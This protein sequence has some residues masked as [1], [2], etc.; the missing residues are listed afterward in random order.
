[1]KAFLKG[2]KKFSKQF[3]GVVGDYLIEVLDDDPRINKIISSSRKK[4]N[5]YHHESSQ[6]RLS[7]LTKRMN[8]VNFSGKALVILKTESNALDEFTCIITAFINNSELEENVLLSD[9]I[10]LA[11]ERWNSILYGGK[12]YNLAGLSKLPPKGIQE[13]LLLSKD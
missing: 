11:S 7:G 12:V 3:L 9:A 13:L 10:R 5:H 1:M 4:L 8:L 2:P 6:S